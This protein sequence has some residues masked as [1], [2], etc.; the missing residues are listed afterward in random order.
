[1]LD[2]LE[3]DA[4]IAATRRLLHEHGKLFHLERC[5]SLL[6]SKYQEQW[7]S[8]IEKSGLSSMMAGNPRSIIR[9]MVESML[10][11][12]KCHIFPSVCVI[13]DYIW[14]WVQHARAGRALRTVPF[15]TWEKGLTSSAKVSGLFSHP[16][17]RR[18]QVDSSKSDSNAATTAGLCSSGLVIGL[19]SY[20][21]P[22]PMVGRCRLEIGVGRYIITHI[23]YP[24]RHSHQSKLRQPQSPSTFL[25]SPFSTALSHPIITASTRH[26]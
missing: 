10:H 13:F 16:Q 4:R 26:V 22:S 2:A 23:S 15:A 18:T 6:D 5:V 14:P 3:S 19:P 9:S 8:R 1:L 17:I 7:P 12:P 21:I 24:S 11:L 20:Y 25:H